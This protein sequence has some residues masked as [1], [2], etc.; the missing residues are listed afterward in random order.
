MSLSIQ[1]HMTGAMVA[2]HIRMERQSDKSKSIV[3][4]EGGTDIKRFKP[5]V[6]S[7]R[8]ILVNCW[9]RQKAVEA[10]HLLQQR[11]PSGIVALIDADFDRMQNQ[12]SNDKR[13]I[14]SE[15]HDFD[16]DWITI[17]I[18]DLYLEQVGDEGKVAA[19]GGPAAIFDKIVDGLRPISGA[20]YLNAQRK[21]P[22]KVS[23]L[24]AGDYF[25]GFA[26][27]IDKY[28]DDLVAK[29]NINNKQKADLKKDIEVAAQGGHNS[30]QFTNGHDF[31]CALGA[32][33]RSEL[34]SRKEAQSY[35]SECEIHF[36]LAF[37]G[38]KFKETT[39]YKDILNWEA[40]SNGFSVLK[41]ELRPPPVPEEAA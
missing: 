11:P 27:D 10:V 33:L 6:D 13:I 5:Y 34:G 2:R 22:Y 18:L 7:G 26:V 23:S 1:R 31:H 36:R 30:L 38:E 28:I 19:Q 29:S 24:N 9:G 39:L 20:R 4:V 21:I 25:A 37:N 12:L 16:L 15:R 14:Y 32:S 40:A 8:C 17:D 41:T 35:G 3:L